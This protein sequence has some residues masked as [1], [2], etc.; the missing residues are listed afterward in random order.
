MDYIENEQL[1]VLEII[2]GHQVDEHIEDDTLYKTDIDPTI[3]ERPIM[4]HVID[5]FI[6]D[7]DKQLSHQ[8]EQATTNDS[9]ELCTMLSFPSGFNETDVMSLKF[10]EDLDNPMGGS[11]SVNDDSSTAQPSATLTPKRRAQSSSRVRALRSRQWEDS[12][13][14]RPWRREAYFVTRYSFQAGDR[15]SNAGTLVLTYLIGF[16]VNLWERDM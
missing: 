15:Q 7:G 13:V 2:V 16:L 11:L 9:D 5:D 8:A 3:V 14:D 12:N 6:D 4:R 1:N 10:T